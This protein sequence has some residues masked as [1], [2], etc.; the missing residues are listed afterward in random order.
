MKASVIIAI[1][2]QQV[3]LERMDTLL[4]FRNRLKRASVTDR[5]EINEIKKVTPAAQYAIMLNVRNT[6]VLR[7]RRS[8]EA[9]FFLQ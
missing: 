3:I 2:K 8:A 6:L 9:R 5:R 1:N 7:T 4:V